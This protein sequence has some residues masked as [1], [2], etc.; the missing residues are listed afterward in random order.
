LFDEANFLPGG[1]VTRWIKIT[2]N[3][4]ES[5][6]IATEAINYPGFPNAG[7]VPAYDLSRVLNIIIRE[8]GGSDLYGGSSLTGEK[9]L[10]NFY[11]DGKLYLTFMK[12]VKLIFLMFRPA[13]IKNTNLKFPFQKKR[14][15]NGRKRQH[16][17]IS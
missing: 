16:I 15:T 8:K 7:N 14:K 4:G 9:T 1:S 6:P 3:G 13:A 10:F 12:T 17:L 5:K 11:E 2:N